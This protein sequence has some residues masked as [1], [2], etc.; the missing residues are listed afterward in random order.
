MTYVQRTLAPGE[1]VQARAKMHWLLW[2]RAWAA[3][4]MFGLIVLGV[5]YFATEWI[6]IANTEIALT[7]RRLIFKTGFFDRH[8]SELE[9]ASV[10]T[11]N[12]DQSFW[13]R[14]FN[15]GRLSVHGTDDAVWTSPMIAA[16]L[17]FRR[18]IEAALAGQARAP[19]ERL[20][21]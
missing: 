3:L 18:A 9:L 15:F 2:A 4:F 12:L 13:G 19:A 11:V 16:P 14:L 8:T 21:S 6:R 20:A 10:E 1:S 5:L 7:D 17:A